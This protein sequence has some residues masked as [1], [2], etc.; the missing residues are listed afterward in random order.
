[1][2]LPFYPHL[3]LNR[4]L[5]PG[6]C[7]SIEHGSNQYKRNCLQ[8]DASIYN[9]NVFFLVIFPK[10]DRFLPDAFFCVLFGNTCTY[11]IKMNF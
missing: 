3:I 2:A 5:T 7:S 1:M 11:R 6:E 8:V 9:I 4:V 10:I